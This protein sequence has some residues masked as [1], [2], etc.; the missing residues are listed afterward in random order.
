M[1]FLCDKQEAVLDLTIR[2]L[3]FVLVQNTHTLWK[4]QAGGLRLQV[5][6]WKKNPWKQGLDQEDTV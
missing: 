4:E 6:A 1:W 3:T 2:I 5:M